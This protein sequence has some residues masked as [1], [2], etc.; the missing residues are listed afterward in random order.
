M[1]TLGEERDN[2]KGKKGANLKAEMFVCDSHE[3]SRLLLQS[4]SRMFQQ[5]RS[6]E[7]HR[8]H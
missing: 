7:T 5:E 1:L 4:S 6:H 8:I 2:E 3:F